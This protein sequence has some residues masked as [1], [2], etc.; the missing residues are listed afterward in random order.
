MPFADFVRDPKGYL[1][2]HETYLN[3]SDTG[4]GSATAGAAVAVPTGN[5]SIL[6]TWNG[7]VIELARDLI[8]QP[9]STRKEAV[10][11]ALRISPKIRRDYSVRAVGGGAADN[12]FR[13][14]PFRQHHVTYMSMDAAA[15]L[16]MTGPLTGCTPAVGRDA[17][18]TLWF[19]HS[20][21][22]HLAGVAARASQLA[23]INHVAGGLGIIL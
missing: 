11:R 7:T 23:M 15:T 6:F 8:A 19:F 20:N 17:A 2:T 9:L 5:H 18:G 3:N 10:K 14:L 1:A 22:N 16:C 21:D 13:L 4:A 12:G